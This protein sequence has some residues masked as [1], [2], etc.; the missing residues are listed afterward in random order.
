MITV[1]AKS[2]LQSTD[3]T[4]LTTLESLSVPADAGGAGEPI[5][6]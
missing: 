2:A 3:R 6:T 5:Y 4:R 1:G